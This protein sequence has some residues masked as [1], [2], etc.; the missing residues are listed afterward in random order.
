MAAGKEISVWLATAVG[1]GAIIGAGI[2]V[3]S[4]TAIALAGADALI[5]FLLVG[6]VALIVAMELGE[7]GTLMPYTK[8]S[9]YS[10]VYKAFGSELGFITGALMYFSLATSI[11]VVALGFGSYLSSM[12]NLT[13]GAYP[14]AFA[15]ALIGALALVN[16]RGLKDAISAD[17]VLVIL[18]VVILLIFVGFAFLI[19]FSR[20]SIGAGHFDFAF[21]ANDINAI[22][23]ASVAVFFAYSGFQA[24]ATFTGRIKGKAVGAA[25][26]LLASVIISIVIYILVV[27][28]L[29]LLLPPSAYK[30]SAD[31]LSF[32]LK[33]S[34]APSWLF[35]LVGVGALIATA[36]AT[37][38]MMLGA[39]RSLY[40]MGMDRLLPKVVRVYD[41]KRDTA[42]NS[43]II[44]AVIGVIMLFSGNIYVIASI[45]N[46]GL[47]FSYLMASFAV[48]HFRRNS[49]V[50]GFR[51]PFYPYLSLAC[52]VA[53][54][55]FF[56][57]MPREALIVGLVITLSLIMVY[58]SLR[59]VKSKKVI[60]IRLF[61]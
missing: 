61:D 18:K 53:L 59:E 47:L 49:K 42:V 40:Q 51:T 25:K 16:I 10:Y 39:S 19:A 6:A 15:I 41:K 43:I 35:L 29:L 57:G 56:I 11:S 30:V 45:S 34:G 9:V 12:M 60:R 52:I 1:L 48:I 27:L 32:A 8:G 26:S 58:Y 22:F 21:S 20:P 17:F 54:M 7:L 14:I 36:S 37:I 38:A 55:A 46:F 23:A 4:G 3:L 44:S 33:Q 13:S 28:A 5:A 2:F 31:P 24:I 50:Q